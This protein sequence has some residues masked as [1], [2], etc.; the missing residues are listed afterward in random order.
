ML[1]KKIKDQ[2]KKVFE[3]RE[4]KAKANMKIMAKIAYKEWKEKKAEET[5]LKRKQ[6]RLER[7]QRMMHDS[8]EREENFKRAGEVLLAY[9]LNKNLKKIRPKSAKP[10]Q[11]NKIQFS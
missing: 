8:P 2:E 7:R 6:E 9:G 11:K 1:Q 4:K 5:R 10:K 3:E